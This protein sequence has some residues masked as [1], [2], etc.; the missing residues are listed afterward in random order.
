[1]V[2]H[3]RIDLVG[4]VLEGVDDPPQ[5]L[6]NLALNSEADRAGVATSLERGFG[7]ALEQSP[8]RVS[9]PALTGE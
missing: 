8:G 2:D 7:A 9:G 6:V 4:N 3:D 5:M 1:M